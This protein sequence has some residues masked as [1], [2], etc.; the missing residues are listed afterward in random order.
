MLINTWTK[1]CIP[2]E[3]CAGTALPSNSFGFWS[4]YGGS[5]NNCDDWNSL[6]TN[7]AGVGFY[8]D[9]DRNPTE[10][11]GYDNFC[12]STAL[13]PTPACCQTDLAIWKPDD[14]HPRPSPIQVA[15]ASNGMDVAISTEDFEIHNDATIPITE[16]KVNVLD[17]EYKYNYEQC[18]E[19]VNNPALWGSIIGTSKIG[20]APNDLSL[21][22]AINIAEN[23]VIN[24][25]NIREIVWKNPDGAVL[26]RGDAFT[27]A[28]VLPPPSEIP[29][30]AAEVKICSKISWK[31]ANC[32][33]CSFTTCSTIDL[34][35]EPSP[36]K[37]KKSLTDILKTP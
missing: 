28:Y 2:I 31:D 34:R 21:L 4:W 1:I 13:C 17:I 14:G 20:A 37:E 35:K 26:K 30:C 19:C 18:A 36:A 25:K 32:N 9:M 6:L 33:V 23:D 29:C 15:T 22:P 7:I 5:G 24:E 11:W 8:F 10:I 3:T 27:L 16:L 12:V